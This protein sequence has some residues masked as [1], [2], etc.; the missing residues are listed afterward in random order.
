[1]VLIYQ[2]LY[3]SLV[4]VGIMVARDT[5]P[6]LIALILSGTTWLVF[7][8]LYTFYPTETW[9]LI[10]AY[11]TLVV[12]LWLI[13]QAL[14]RFIFLAKQVTLDVI[15]AACAVYLLLGALFVPIYGITEVL[16]LAQT[17]Q[18]AIVDSMVTTAELPT[19]WQSLIY[20]SYVSL[21]TMGYGDI[22]PV[23]AWARSIASMQAVIGVLY[24]TIIMARLVGLYAQEAEAD[25]EERQ[26][27]EG[28]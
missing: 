6:H 1:M 3:G 21:T 4:V 19:P 23:S 8:P 7:G 24:V 5:R 10:T 25:Y 20:Y 28:P 27:K 2:L 14:L 12:F 26:S 18:H 13:I 17:G 22:L 11:L 9:I 15:Y 16:T